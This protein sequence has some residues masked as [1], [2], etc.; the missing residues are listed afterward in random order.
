MRIIGLF[1]STVFVAL[2]ITGHAQN[3]QRMYHV[4]EDTLR[5]YDAGA[6][7]QVIVASKELI[8]LWDI[9]KGQKLYSVRPGFRCSV[10]GASSNGEF[11]VLT[12]DSK[13]YVYSWKED[14]LF[15]LIDGYSVAGIDEESDRICIYN[16]DKHIVKTVTFLSDNY[17][18]ILEDAG[19]EV[20]H[21]WGRFGRFLAFHNKTSGEIKFSDINRDTIFTHKNI[22]LKQKKAR[23]FLYI[24]PDYPHVSLFKYD[25]KG[26][27]VEKQGGYNFVTGEEIPGTMD[28]IG[29][30]FGK[31]YWVQPDYGIYKG[32]GAGY[33]YVSGSSS[34]KKIPFTRTYEPIAYNGLGNYLICVGHYKNL[35][36][37]SCET[38]EEVKNISIYTKVDKD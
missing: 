28:N 32:H 37:Y 30:Y 9:T 33:A 20:N 15:Q 7:D 25:K 8:C 12:N 14:T 34:V 10:S 35:I 38:G 29:R 36:V 3:S 11:V 18:T 24:L 4:Y 19:F 6:R 21:Y 13:S 23:V 26:F 2:C 17:K 16:R 31:L 22:T 27:N 5:Y 1:L